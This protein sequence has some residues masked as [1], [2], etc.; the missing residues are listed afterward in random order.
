MP[1]RPPTPPLPPAPLGLLAILVFL[2]A[3]GRER[4]ESGTNHRIW[5]TGVRGGVSIERG[6]V[7][8]EIDGALFD[9]VRE[10]DAAHGSEE[11]M[12]VEGHPLSLEGGR[13]RLGETD[14]GKVGPGD[15]VRMTGEGVIVDGALRGPFPAS[16]PAR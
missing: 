16:R 14:Y 2:L 3:C 9:M 15:V 5:I 4:P 8:I 6:G 10:V 13:L 12:T 1:P 7:R 11:R